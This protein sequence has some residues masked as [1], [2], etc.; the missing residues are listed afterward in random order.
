MVLPLQKLI[1]THIEEECDFSGSEDNLLSPGHNNQAKS[2]RKTQVSRW[3]RIL[4]MGGQ[5][6]DETAPEK[7]QFPN[8]TTR[9][10][11]IPTEELS[12]LPP[13][14]RTL[15]RYHGSTNVERTEYMEENSA[16][17]TKRLAVAVEQVSIFLTSDNTVV[18]FF[19]QSAGDIEDPILVRL[20]S[21]ET[22]LR[23]TSNA[24]M[25][26]QAILDAIVDLA[27]PV[28]GAYR[29]AIDELE[30]NVLTEPAIKHTRSLY[31]IAS[32]ISSF[33]DTIYPISQLLSALRDHKAENTR[34]ATGNN[35]GYGHGNGA[36]EKRAVTISPWSWAY[37]GDVEDH[38]V[39]ITDNL[40]QQRRSV[41]NVS[42]SP[43]F[44]PPSKPLC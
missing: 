31:I 1:H 25:I 26:V 10:N 11:K 35:D 37:F 2:R 4:G 41:E 36:L 43:S 27:M 32:E 38:V 39:L 6:Q 15:Q 24:S 17:R 42:P 18:S 34:K 20:N 21:G 28:C 12:H 33:R 16:L 9:E 40:D 19:E 8:G 23:R 44:S 30:L 22:V 5:K 3:R 14:I 7:P 29:D 13:D